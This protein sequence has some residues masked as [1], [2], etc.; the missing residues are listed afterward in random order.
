MSII[1][2]WSYVYLM[3]PKIFL[4]RCMEINKEMS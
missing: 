3:G 4:Y 2:N 1:Y